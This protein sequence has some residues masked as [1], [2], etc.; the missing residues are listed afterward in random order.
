M[1]GHIRS[2]SGIYQY[3]YDD[4]RTPMHDVL[5]LVAD[6]VHNAQLGNIAQLSQLADL[7]A[8]LQVQTA[9]AYMRLVRSSNWSQTSDGVIPFNQVQAAS[10]GLS[11]DGN[12]IRVGV[13]GVYTISFDS[14]VQ[15]NEADRYRNITIM[16]NGAAI[17]QGTFSAAI[18]GTNAY[19]NVSM[20]V[21]LTA[22][23]LVTINATGDP[24]A[25]PSTWLQNRT[26]LTI[27]RI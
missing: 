7:I 6:S 11:L 8:A 17:D 10:G 12:G 1:P 22:G 18:N 23:D 15:Q 24:R 2:D 20:P 21:Q 19:L 3:A 5:N 14:V 27:V 16:R 13:S 9:P 4:P 25:L 26:R